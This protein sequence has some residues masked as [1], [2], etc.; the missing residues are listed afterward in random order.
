MSAA[1]SSAS[2]ATRPSSRS[3]L[4]GPITASNAAWRLCLHLL[5]V[6]LVEEAEGLGERGCQRG[7]ADWPGPVPGQAGA[8]GLPVAFPGRFCGGARPPGQPGCPY[9]G[10]RPARS[11]YSP[12]LSFGA[13]VWGS[14][15]GDFC[16][17]FIWRSAFCYLRQQ[18]VAC[19]ATMWVGGLGG[20]AAAAGPQSPCATRAGVGSP[21]RF[22]ELACSG[23]V[24]ENN[25]NPKQA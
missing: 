15:L 5:R 11:S 17:T 12:F 9:T 19:V 2:F 4:P 14:A 16:S 10:G 25:K 1:F 24:C 6:F 22:W 21:P 13:L 23:K 3:C 8:S 18:T 20:R 7:L